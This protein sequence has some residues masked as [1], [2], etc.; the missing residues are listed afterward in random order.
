MSH[1]PLSGCGRDSHHPC[2]DRGGFTLVELLVVIGII[3]LL[4]SILLPALGKAREAAR[5]VVCESNERQIMMAFLLFATEHQQHL[6]GNYF[7]SIKQQPKDAEK[8]D[9]LLGDDPN[10]GTP[11]EYLDGPQKGTIYRYVKD[12]KVYL[13]PSYDHWAFDLNYGSNGRF[14]YASTLSF[15]GAKV[16]HVNWRVRFHYHSGP[17]ANTYN[18]DEFTPIVVEEDPINGI[19]GGNTEGGH[20]N[21]DRLGHYHR[22]GGH[23]ASIDGSVHWFKEPL[24]CSSWDWESKAPSGAFKT[25]G[26]WQD[27]KSPSGFVMWGYWDKQ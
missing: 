15:A 5:A 27:T 3:G 21:T 13:C 17:Y 22:G 1:F 7:D 6:P 16:N 23:Y 12:P 10:Q 11:Q 9:W 8:R 2:R 19:N 26:N 24:D 25:L 4:I 20:S 14:D 18:Y